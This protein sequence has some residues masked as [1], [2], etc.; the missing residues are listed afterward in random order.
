MSEEIDDLE[1]EITLRPVPLAAARLLV[2]GAV[3]RRA[4]LELDPATASASDDPEGDRFDLAA[5]LTEGG[6]GSLHLGN[7]ASVA[8]PANREP[9]GRRRLR[10]PVGKSKRPR[11]LAWALELLE[12]SPP[13]DAPID[14][15]TLLAI[16]P[17]PWDKT[18][19]F[20]ENAELLPEEMI[21]VERERAELWYWRASVEADR[22]GATGRPG[23]GTQ[24]GDRTK[25][26]PKPPPPNSSSARSTATSR[27]AAVVSFNAT[28]APGDPSR[29]RHGATPR[30]Q[31]AV[32]PR[33]LLACPGFNLAMLRTA[34]Y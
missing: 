16:L 9:G 30:A 28:S 20:R 32:R 14:P 3:C 23:E 26:P 21:A 1:I 17:S 10:K 12:D 18:R 6:P 34:G 27:L 24:R 31:L 13:L 25:L 11:A 33:P 15:A 4:F 5:W 22:A 7:G 8:Q 2:V 29:R 19:P